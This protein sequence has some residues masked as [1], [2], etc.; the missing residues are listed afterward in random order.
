MLQNLWNKLS[1]RKTEMSHE[2]TFKSCS[3]QFV[4]YKVPKYI[5]LYTLNVPLIKSVI[6]LFI[7]T[8]LCSGK[9][10]N[11]L[12]DCRTSFLHEWI[13]NKL[14]LP[15]SSFTFQGKQNVQSEFLL[16]LSM[17]LKS[18]PLF[19]C[20]KLLRYKISYFRSTVSRTRVEARLRGYGPGTKTKCREPPVLS[21]PVCHHQ[22]W[23]RPKIGGTAQP[24]KL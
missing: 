1:W 14:C 6:R 18:D 4:C 24:F 20:L 13:W 19:Y 11:L 12:K 9:K 23:Q 15:K 22:H 17:T 5:K 7:I 2:R 10:L 3:A 8:I 21:W 16:S